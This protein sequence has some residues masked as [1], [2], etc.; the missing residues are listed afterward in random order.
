METPAQG[1]LP[2]AAQCSTQSLPV[3]WPGK[4]MEIQTRALLCRLA[5]SIAYGQ[6]PASESIFSTQSKGLVVRSALVCWEALCS[7]APAKY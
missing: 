4:S 6:T 7:L 2:S 3:A 1:K 5:G